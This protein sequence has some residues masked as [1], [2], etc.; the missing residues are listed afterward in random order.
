MERKEDHIESQP[1]SESPAPANPPSGEK[2]EEQ[3]K[4]EGT[5]RKVKTSIGNSSVEKAR[6]SIKPKDQKA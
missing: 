5:I 2:K 1:P 6:E 3:E 4:D